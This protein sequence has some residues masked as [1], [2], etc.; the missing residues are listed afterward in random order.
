M[1]RTPHTAAFLALG[2]VLLFGTAAC[3]DSAPEADA[4]G[5]VEK[6]PEDTDSAQSEKNAAEFRAWAEKNG[7]AEEKDAVGR[8]QRILGEWDSKTGN[9]YVSTDINGGKSE[10]K[11][12]QGAANTIAEAFA[13]WKDS[14]QGYVSVYDVF[15]NAMITNHKF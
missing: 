12:P 4:V 10:V 14:D 11:D 9:A 7:N 1:K 2:A 15:G 6:L 13:E 5:V 8:V 3:T